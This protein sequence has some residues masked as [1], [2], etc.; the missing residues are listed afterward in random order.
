MGVAKD[1]ANE[2]D[3]RGSVIVNTSDPKQNMSV[4][5]EK[6]YC[7]MRGDNNKLTK[8]RGSY[9]NSKSTNISTEASEHLNATKTRGYKPRDITAY[10][11]PTMGPQMRGRSFHTM[12]TKNQKGNSEIE[13]A[14]KNQ[15]LEHDLHT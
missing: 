11:N 15:V 12:I 14:N 5:A 3:T 10:C 2:L 6:K 13:L 7:Y 8:N 4:G 1:E 9:H